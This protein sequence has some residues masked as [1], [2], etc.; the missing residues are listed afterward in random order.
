MKR[1]VTWVA[2]SQQVARLFAAADGIVEMMHLDR[3]PFLQPLAVATPAFIDN[4]HPKIPQQLFKIVK[5]L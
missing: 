2:N 4:L 3:G 1:V 5:R